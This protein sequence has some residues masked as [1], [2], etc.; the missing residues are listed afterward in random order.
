MNIF[1]NLDLIL[2]FLY[3]VTLLGIGI[4]IFKKN[5]NKNA[6]DFLIAERKLGTFST[7]ATMNASKTGAILMTYVAM[8]YIWGMS[9]IWVFVGITMGFLVFLP[10]ALKLKEQSH[11]QY[12]TLADYFKHNY[13]KG[14]AIFASCISIFLMFGNAIINIIAG[15]KIFTFF[16]GWPFWVCSVIMTAIILIYLLLGGFKAVAKTDVLQYIAITT[17]LVIV[18]V[19][20]FDGAIIPQSD[21]SLFAVDIGTIIGFFLIGFIFPFA[22]P[23]L[24]QRVYA[25]KDK[26]ALKRGFIASVIVYMITAIFLS[27]IAL[28][29]KTNFP[30]IDPDLALIHGFKNLLSPGLV[31]LSIVLLFAAIMSSLDT[32]IFT[33]VSSL[34][35]GFSKS[36][37]KEKIVKDIKKVILGFGIIGVILSILIQ[38][39]VIGTFLVNSFVAVLAVMVISTWIKKTIRQRTLIYG[40]VVGILSTTI[41]LIMNLLEGE[42]SPTIMLVGITGSLLGLSIG[43]IVSFV[44]VKNKKV[45]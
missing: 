22:S 9:A 35:Q 45:I 19:Y 36:E 7:M 21:W 29:V 18:S 42:V 31:G 34:V 43:G 24:W 41:F 11:K 28:T 20:I 30:N 27:L 5:K 13:G 16:I 38:N 33:G 12:Y 15:T 26:T 44:K 25:A 40:F 14:A 6:E 3:F 37:D 23:D 8:T 1:S 4:F 32:Y 17:I 39:L 2:I 10:F